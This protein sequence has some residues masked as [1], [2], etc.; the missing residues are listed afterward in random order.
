MED[1]K[2]YKST[3]CVKLNHPEASTVFNVICTKEQE[4]FLNFLANISTNVSMNKYEPT[5]SV[6]KEARAC[7]S[8][9]LDGTKK[10]FIFDA[11]ILEG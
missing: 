8:D 6:D 10:T 3:I 9:A 11:T 4:K 7:E 2:N 1:K 5:M